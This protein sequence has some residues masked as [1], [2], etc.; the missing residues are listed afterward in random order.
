MGDRSRKGDQ[1]FRL[2]DP[3]TQQ[4]AKIDS[5]GRLLVSPEAATPADTTEVIRVAQSSIS[6]NND[7]IYTVTNG[8]ILTLQIFQSGAELNSIGG[9]KVSLYEDPNGNLSV[10]NLIVVLYVNGSSAEASISTS[11]VGN[12]TR[13]LVMRRSVF[14]GSSREV[15][16]RWKGFEV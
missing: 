4:A 3:D 2:V 8:K 16:G 1:E 13:R 6:G 14:S 12:G 15:F 7:T 5:S 9:S 11:L 10:L